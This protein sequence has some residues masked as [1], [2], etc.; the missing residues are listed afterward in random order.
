MSELGD[1]SLQELSGRVDA[2][3][4]HIQDLD[5][6]TR[7]G[8]WLGRFLVMAIAAAAIFS[9]WNTFTSLRAI[10]PHLYAHYAAEQA[11]YLFPTLEKNA[12][13]VVENIA[14]VYEQ[15]FRKEF[16]RAMPRISQKAGEELNLFF[17]HIGDRLE[18]RLEKGIRGIVDAHVKS[19]AAEH[20]E[21]KDAARREKVVEQA[22][23]V[24]YA[25]AQ[26]VTREVLSE[27]TNALAD[28]GATLETFEIPEE[29]KNLNDEKLIERIKDCL[30]EF[31]ALRLS[32]VDEAP[33][34]GQSNATAPGG[35][36]Q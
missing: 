23:E 21:L 26:G 2:L 10:P 8:K 15:A 30:L 35:D 24:Y 1:G 5:S 19:L 32:L 22:K 17:I 18:S 7:R 4:R 33:T 34:P 14:P 16:E 31:L 6:T 29:I 36:P 20:P 12:R 27:Q 11:D 9:L 25:A 13:K 28:L 3:R